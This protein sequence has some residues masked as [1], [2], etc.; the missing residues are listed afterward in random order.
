MPLPPGAP[1][2]NNALNLTLGGGALPLIFVTPPAII[3]ATGLEAYIF[4]FNFDTEAPKI[5]KTSGIYRESSM[6]FMTARSTDLSPFKHRGG[7][8]IIYNGNSDGVF[9]SRD[10]VRWYDAM[11]ARMHGKAQSFARLF[12]VPGMG[13][14]AL[15]PSTY[16]FDAFTPLVNWVEHGIAPD[17]IVAMAPPDTPWPGRTRPLCPYPKQTRYKGSGNIDDAANFVCEMPHFGHGCD[18]DDFDFHHFDD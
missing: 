17:S 3:P 13:H 18:F 12:L 16:A 4:G 6:E 7:K 15:G 11:N 8:M 2:V 5:F 9:S 1:L 14:C 10:I